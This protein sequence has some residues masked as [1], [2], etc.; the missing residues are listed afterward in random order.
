MEKESGFNADRMKELKAALK[1]AEEHAKTEKKEFEKTPEMRAAGDPPDVQAPESE[2]GVQS[3]EKEESQAENGKPER[4]EPLPKNEKP[5]RTESL[6][7]TEKPDRTEKPFRSDPAED[8]GASSYNDTPEEIRERDRVSRE[9]RHR[10]QQQR[11][12][13]L[14]KMYMI[15]GAV[16]F[17]LLAA[18]LIGKAIAG[19][20]ER[21]RQAQLEEEAR[22]LA[23]ATPEPDR[24][25]ESITILG[26]GDNLIH[27][28]L[29]ENARTGDTYDFKPYYVHVKEQVQAADIATVNQET[30]LASDLYDLSTYPKFNSPKQVGEALIDAGFDVINLGNNHVYDMGDDGAAITKKVFDNRDTM[31]VGL[32]DGYEDIFNIRVVEKN[33]IKVSFVSFVDFVNGDPEDGDT[34]IVWL[35]DKTTVAK[36]IAAAKEVSDIVVAHVHWGEELTFDLQEKQKEMAQFLVD[37]GVDI[38]FGNHSHWLQELTVLTR[39]SDGTK[40]P[41]IYSLGN[42]VS[43]MD[44]RPEIITGFLT[45]TVKRN[46]TKGVVVPTAMEF[47]PLVEH[48]STL[49]KKD[50]AIWPLT[51]YTEEMAED[52]AVNELRGEFNLEYI[53]GVIKPQ[54]P[55]QYLGKMGEFY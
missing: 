20:K 40:C 32:Y 29:Y 12:K 5:E 14:R 23:E 39:S 42:F 10:R 54:I 50:L 22:A 17:V 9:R 28:Q 26:C 33:G 49:E 37:E 38:I 7:K 2:Q 6:P 47:T 30:P 3:P 46:L 1:A 15:A 45:V 4:T 41:V 21:R 52:N 43:G 19:A 48:F 53:D 51:E 34:E 27:R 16:I 36:N 13:Q 44:R 25:G 35:D 31:T 18:L 11:K 55:E 8:T 24:W